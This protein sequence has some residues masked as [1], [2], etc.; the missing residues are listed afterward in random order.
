MYAR[1][2]VG[3]AYK[4]VNAGKT[5]IPVT[6]WIG[7]EDVNLTGIESIALDP[8]DP[9]RVYLAAGTYLKSGNGAILRSRDLCRTFDRIDMPVKMGANEMGRGNGERLC[10]DPNCGKVLFFGSRKAG[11]WRSADYG[12]TWSR[13]NGFP[14]T[15]ASVDSQLFDDT[16]REQYDVGIVAVVFD[17]ATGRRGLPTPAVYAAVSTNGTS[18]FRSLDRGETWHPLPGQPVGLRPNHLVRSKNGAFYVSYGKEP[19]PNTMTDGALW[20]FS[21]LDESWTDITPEKP[22]GENVFGYGSVSVDSRDQGVIVVTS[23]CRYKRKDDIFR[24]T[25]GGKTWKQLLKDAIYDYGN[26]PWTE[27]T[28]VHWMADVEIDPFDSDHIMFT[29]GYGIWG[30]VNATEADRG[31]RTVW[32]F[33]CTGLEECVPLGLVSPSEGPHLLS[34]IGDY[35]GFKHDDVDVSPREGQ[36]KAPPRY[37]NSEFISIARGNPRIV[38]RSGNFRSDESMPGAYSLDFGTTWSAFPTLPANASGHGPLAISS[39]GKL[40]VW[41]LKEGGPHVTSDYGVSWHA[42]EGLRGKPRIVSDSVNPGTFYAF[43]AESGELFMSTDGALHFSKCA[44]DIPATPD[45]NGGFG[46]EG[47]P[48]AMLFA[49]PAAGGDLWIALRRSGILRTKDSGKTFFGL[50][51]VHEAYSLGF[52]KGASGKS[53]PAVFLAGR[54]DGIIGLFRSDDEGR[55]WIRITDNGHQ[56]GWINHV[57]GDPRIFGRVYFGTGGRGIVYG[58]RA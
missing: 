54:I 9:R 48:G 22:G 37:Q 30:S 51:D 4:S 13:V 21:P 14:E 20:R 10:V 7:M 36:Y 33:Q 6:D 25:D 38:A 47:G 5:W 57:T 41:S 43:N 17:P 35:D 19:G 49:S 44:A 28:F 27:N 15:D 42:C 40:I 45:F 50:D 52:G 16:L 2:D 32:Q 56:F 24:S 8:N 55:S 39:D 3:G 29:T 11:L 46:G 58:D 1:T 26:A 31:G 34:A 12:S 53:Y 18:L 23:F